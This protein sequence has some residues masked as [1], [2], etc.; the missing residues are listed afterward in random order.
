MGQSMIKGVIFDIDGVV[1]DS[2][3]IWED[4][5][6]RFLSRYG[7]EPDSD[8][9]KRIV[10]MTFAESSVFIKEH[11]N[12]PKEPE[13]ILVEI[14]DVTRE[15]YD[16]EIELKSGIMTYLDA[17]R[18]RGLGI[19]AA[20][21]SDRS[22]IEAAFRRLGIESYFDAVFTCREL[23]TAKTE[24]L[25]YL[26][27]AESIGADK[28]EVIVFEDSLYAIDTLNKSGFKIA[29]VRDGSSLKDEKAIR[30]LSD[31]YLENYDSFDLF[32]EAFNL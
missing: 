7:A 10:Q 5:M 28:D 13:E 27:A 25:I 9:M 2:M 18:D 29:A 6:K 24:P 12:I 17:L 20:T 3:W 32:S 26:R 19:A 14:F 31:I 22:Y 15:F 11:Y 8:L 1:L 23:D 16:N 4:V 30:E 21:A